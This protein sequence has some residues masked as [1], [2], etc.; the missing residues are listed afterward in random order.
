MSD[1]E[2][3]FR[4]RHSVRHFKSDR[5]SDDHLR[6]I[7]EAA[8]LAPTARNVQPWEFVLVSDSKRRTR[9][10][11]MVSS[12]GAFLA[13]APVCLVIV[14]AD[15]KYY[16]EDGCAATTQALLCASM[17]GLGACWIAGDKKEYA[18]QVLDFLKVK[19]GYKLVSLIPIGYAAQETVPT[20]K[21][22]SSLIH[23]E[24]F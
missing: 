17:L 19:P 3:I 5:V 1:P 24:E 4:R 12:N 21:D 2:Q 9:L 7:I 15:T 10:A 18:G 8:S 6:Q 23:F 14:C 22:L 11:E 13:Q 16:L 20:K